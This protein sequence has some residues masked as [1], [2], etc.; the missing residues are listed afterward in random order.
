MLKN[1]KY[2]WETRRF[3]WYIATARTR[4]RF[5]RTALGSFWLGFSNLLSIGTL[6][7][8]YGTVFAVENFKE[9]FIYLG[10]GLVIWNSISLSIASGPELFANNNQ[11]I[12]NM[13]IN[14]IVYTLEEWSFQIQTFFQSFTLVFFV[15]LFIQKSL[16]LNLIFFSWLPLIN[17]II[18]LYWFP[19]VIALIGIRYSDFSQLVPIVLQ[20]TFLTSPILYRKESLGSLEWITNYNLLYKI[21]DPLRLSII[22]GN[23]DLKVVIITLLINIAG[24]YV[25]LFLFKKQYHKLPFLI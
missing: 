11:N 8:I 16:I 4:A 7:I 18:F 14:P 25:S 23:L 6:G 5:A 22:E 21:L 20:L 10:I 12:K 3:W 9:Y 15:L 1:I 2:G 17:L 19:L 24:F 13:N